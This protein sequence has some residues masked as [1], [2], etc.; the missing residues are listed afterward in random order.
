MARYIIKPGQSIPLEK[1]NGTPIFVSEL[2][3]DAFQGE[4]PYSGVPSIFLRLAGC[5]LGCVWCDSRNIWSKSTRLGTRDLID[6]FQ[7]YGLIEKLKQGTHLVITGG[8]PM[9]QQKAVTD[10]LFTLRSEIERYIFVEVETEASIPVQTDNA[11][12]W[13]LV[14]CWNVSPKLSTSGVDKGKRYCPDALAQFGLFETQT[15]FKFVVSSPEE[16]WK[17]IEEHFLLPG[18]CKKEQIILMPEGQTQEELTPEKKR[19]VAEF[20]VEKGVRYGGRLQIDIYSNKQ[21]V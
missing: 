6:I 16:N 12:L 18:F 1:V 10:L 4:G 19:I 15:W 9:L 7:E 11:S 17:E 13:F 5:P 21:G 20:A 8:S 2:F 3:S 14:N